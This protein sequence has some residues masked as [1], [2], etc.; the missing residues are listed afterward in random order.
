MEKYD[1]IVGVVAETLVRAGSSFRE[2]QIAAYKRVIAEETN[3][4]SK[5]VLE[6]ILENAM[7]AAKEHSPLCDDTGIPH[8]FLEVGEKRAI[9][10]EMLNAIHEGIA[11]GLRL[12]PGRPMSIIGDDLERIDQSGSLSEDPG[13]VLPAPIVI[14]KTV[15]DVVRLHV[16]MQGGGPAIRGKT[17]RIF[18]RHSVDVVMNK[19]VEWS[20]EAVAKLGCSPC[21]LVIGIGRTHYEATAMMLEA[22]VYAD[23]NIQS[24][25]EKTI[26]DRVNESNVGALGL[27]GKTSV[28]ATFLKVGPQRASGVRIVCLSPNCCIEPRI[29]TVEL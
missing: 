16:I 17:Y 11:E 12:L 20:K 3:P 8:L 18:H 27:G 26:T 25:I 21:S 15:E 9:S 19:I 22:Q 1:E 6:T 28:L 23:F 13:D 2:D 14:K 4:Q 24:D 29:A 5:W 10:G 7:V